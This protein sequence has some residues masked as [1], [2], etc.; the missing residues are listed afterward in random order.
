VQTLNTKRK[1][2]FEGTGTN[3]CVASPTCQC[4]CVTTIDTAWI[5]SNMSL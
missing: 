2:F 5:I 4:Q 1:G 3:T